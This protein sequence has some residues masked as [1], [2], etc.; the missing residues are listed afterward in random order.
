LR[1]KFDD[2]AEPGRHLL[3]GSATPANAPVHSG[4]G[5]IVSVR[6]RP[7]TLAEQQIWPPT[8]SLAAML[9]IEGMHDWSG[10]RHI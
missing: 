8:V 4:A 2:G 3:T 5:W 7:L 10:E 9:A 1:R 6:M